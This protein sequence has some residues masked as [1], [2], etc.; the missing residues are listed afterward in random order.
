MDGGTEED[1]QARIG[2]ARTAFNMLNNIWKM[3]NLSLKTKLQIFNSN[4]K[5]T[6]LYGSETWKIT[7][8]ILTKL[9][10]FINRCL[11]RLLGI[12]WPNIIS[13][14]NLWELTKQETIETQIRKWKWLG[15]TLRRQ[16]SITKQALTWNP[17][18]RR[19]RGRPRTSWRR[20]TEL[21]MK[22][23]GLSWQQLERRAQDR[24][25]WRDFVDGLCS[26]G[27]LKA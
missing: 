14:A 25:G 21:E 16:K 10:T 26:Y 8:T 5:S 13:N 12:Y 19:K 24:K 11:R 3:K 23:E 2:K 27:N 7:T 1:V 22:K 6:L 17:Q 4:V 15:H 9:Q 18:G 20:T